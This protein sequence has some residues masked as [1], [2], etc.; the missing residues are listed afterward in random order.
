MWSNLRLVVDL[1]WWRGWICIRVDCELG[2]QDQS[3]WEPRIWFL[4]RPRW[5]D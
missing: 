5:P 3:W 1:A 2:R 4:S